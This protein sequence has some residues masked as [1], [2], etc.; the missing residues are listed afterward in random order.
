MNNIEFGRLMDLPLREAWKHE[1]L[2]F[3]PWLAKNILHLSEAKSL[4]LEIVGTE[5]AVESFSADVLV[6]NP[7]G[8]TFFERTAS[9]VPDLE[10]SLGVI[11]EPGNG[12]RFG[13]TRATSLRDDATWPGIQDW[14]ERALQRYLAALE[15]AA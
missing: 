8:D 12:T 11:D 5:V 6:C 15:S 10:R 7:I 4:P 14:Q 1:A 9:L 13:Q 3:T 2:E